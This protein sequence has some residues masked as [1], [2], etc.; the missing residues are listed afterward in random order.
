M[1]TAAVI[2]DRL[3]DT[4]ATADEPARVQVVSFMLGDELF[5][6]PMSQVLE[7]MRYPRP[8]KVPMTP[9]AL[10]GMASLRGTVAPIID[11]RL[12]L[13]MPSADI[14]DSNRVLLVE[15]G[16]TL[17]LVVDHVDRVMDLDD[18]DLTAS[19]QV[20]SIDSELLSGVYHTGDDNSALMQML[21]LEALLTREFAI[22]DEDGH[23][24][25][26][27]GSVCGLS[28]NPESTDVASSL[29]QLV[30]L[31][32]AQQ[33][34]A[35]RLDD[36]QEIVR[37]PDTVNRTPNANPALLGLITRRN[38]T[39]PLFSLRALLG[40]A[41]LDDEQQPVLVVLRRGETRLALAVDQVNAVLRIEESELEPVPP[42]LARDPGMADIAAIC[43]RGEG[44]RLLSVLTTDALFSAADA[45]ETDDNTTAESVAMT[46]EDNDNDDCQLVVFNLE[47]QQYGIDIHHVQEITRLP[48]RFY[49]VPRSPAFIEGMMNLRGNVLPVVDLRTRFDLERTASNERQRIL[50]LTLEG[51]TTGFIVDSV[52]EV[53]RI[54]RQHIEPSPALSAAQQALFGEVVR[55]SDDQLIQLLT[56]DALI[57]HKEAVA[58]RDSL[59]A[60]NGD[61]A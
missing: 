39:L 46:E 12:L 25:L 14:T 10:L 41:P 61:A 34:Y 16:Q 37:L 29:I 5:A 42:M 35:F 54:Q 45:L 11:L 43:R 57:N 15:H 40:L 7:I 33:D 21:N 50:V 17:G 31:S 30:S 4:S 47:Q 23:R 38:K 22:A 9:P 49:Q 56:V 58:L 18:Q 55:T 3:D 8:I 13:G 32:V 20:G 52:S 27:A 36:V 1:N 48:E 2:D 24:A 19:S 53:R 60:D 59:A 6:L 51:V 44:Q 26:F 28:A